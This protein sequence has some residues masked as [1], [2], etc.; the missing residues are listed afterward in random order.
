M[1]VGRGAGF[2]LPTETTVHVR[3][4]APIESRVAYFAQW[5]RLT[6]E[7]AAA[8]VQARDDRRAQFLTR[9]LG[10]DPA[11]STGY[12]MMVNVER[13]GIEGNGAVYRLG[14]A[15]K[16]DVRRDQGKRLRSRAQRLAGF[17]TESDPSSQCPPR[18]PSS[19]ASLATSPR[20][21]RHRA[22]LG[23]W[24][25][26]LLRSANPPRFPSSDIPGL[27]PTTI[28][29]HHKGR[30]AVGHWHD[31]PALL[32]QG[33]L[34][35]YEG[36]PREVV[37]GTVRIAADL[38]I[39]RL[40]LTNAAGGIHPSLVPGSLM[41]IR[42]HIKLVGRDA[43]KELANG[44]RVTEP[45]TPQLL[46]RMP[47]LFAGV[48]AAL[49]GPSYETPAEIRALAACG[50]AAV[51]MST[52]LEVE[53]AAELGLEVAG[54]SCVTNKAAGGLSAAPLDHEEV[55]DTAEMIGRLIGLA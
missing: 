26:S 46:A 24:A 5:L 10:R 30:L 43:W 14:R 45:Y 20:K 36:H 55:L 40:I 31:T 50:A 51:G 22:W 25:A 16:A 23:A 8:E 42:G 21:T 48:Y 44:M 29:R 34:H 27:V 4:V 18:S 17:V 15:N 7:E 38:G 54:I 19:C 53:A 49:T 47:E 52:A 28:S 33:R 12:D 2:L 11:D 6:R 32:C 3:V 13:L 37:T 35:F 1:I 9:T 39:K 41:A